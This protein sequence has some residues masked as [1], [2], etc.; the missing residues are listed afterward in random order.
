VATVDDTVKEMTRAHRTLVHI[1]Y[2]YASADIPWCPMYYPMVQ[3]LG[4]VG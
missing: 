2:A 4:M 1:F 3:P